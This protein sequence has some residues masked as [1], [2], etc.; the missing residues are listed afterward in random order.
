MSDPTI[1][2][3][4]RVTVITPQGT[5]HEMASLWAER[6]IVLAMIRHFG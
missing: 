2:R 1:E 3:L 6:P 4:G 5:E